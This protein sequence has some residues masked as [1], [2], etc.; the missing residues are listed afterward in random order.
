MDSEKI[1]EVKNLSVTLDN[2]NILQDVSFDVTRGQMA[3]VV[4]PNGAGKTVLFKALLNLLPFEGEANWKENINLGYVPQKLSV[5]RSIPATVREFFLLK[6]NDFWFP[7]RKFI[8]HIEHELNLVGLPLDILSKPLGELSG[9]QFQRLMIG[10]AML[11]HPD[12]LLF[13]E[14]TTGIDVGSEET[15]FNI[16]QKLQKERKTTVLL[17]SHDLNII[18]QYAQY[19]LVLNRKIICQGSPAQVIKSPEL[20]KFYG[21]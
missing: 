1:L 7:R 19:V 9:G 16:I 12:V 6:A 11:D 13:D 3:A 15:I 14:P 8:D 20:K 17:I 21:K 10:W 18:S 5:D 4:G 2:Q